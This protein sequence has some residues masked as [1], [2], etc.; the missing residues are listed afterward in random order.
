[1][2]KYEIYIFKKKD[3]FLM[4]EEKNNDDFRE[5]LGY[6]FGN[7]RIETLRLMEIW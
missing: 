5:E 6:I 7:R 3:K 1:M 4:D 2:V